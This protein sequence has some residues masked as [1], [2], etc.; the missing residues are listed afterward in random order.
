MLNLSGI[1]GKYTPSNNN[2]GHYSSSISSKKENKEKNKLD[3]EFRSNKGFK[4][5]TEKKD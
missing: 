1:N 3:I 5:S 2:I 4:P